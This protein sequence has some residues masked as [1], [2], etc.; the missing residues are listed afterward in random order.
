MPLL[1]SWRGVRPLWVIRAIVIP[2]TAGLGEQ[3]HL[4]GQERAHLDM[5]Q[6][7][8]MLRDHARRYNLRLADVARDVIRGILAVTALDPEA[9]LG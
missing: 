6:A 5:A 1:L 9:T 8:S 4:H 7:F 2:A 3:G